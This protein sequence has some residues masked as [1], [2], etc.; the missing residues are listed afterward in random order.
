MMTAQVAEEQTSRVCEEYDRR[1]D[2]ER[3]EAEAGTEDRE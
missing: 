2:V 1:I 3:Q